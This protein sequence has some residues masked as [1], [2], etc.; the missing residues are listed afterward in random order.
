MRLTPPKKIVFWISVILAVLGLIAYFVSI[1]FLSEY[2]FW[3]V[4][5]GYVLLFLGNA[6]KG[7]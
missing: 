2:K 6:V 7:F 5:I 4:F 3:V 1:P